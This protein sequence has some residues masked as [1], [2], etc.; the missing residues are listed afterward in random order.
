MGHQP[1]HCCSQPPTTPHLPNLLP[2]RESESL[3]LP[4]PSIPIPAAPR[5]DRGSPGAAIAPAATRVHPA[6]LMYVSPQLGT[7]LPRL[8]PN[9]ACPQGAWLLSGPSQLLGFSLTLRVSRCQALCQRRTGQRSFTHHFPWLALVVS[10]SPFPTAP[11]G[12]GL[13]LSHSPLEGD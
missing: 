9:A 5:G 3:W 8:F 12:N 7:L 10:K 4:A 1:P 6:L 2:Q 13:I 11:L